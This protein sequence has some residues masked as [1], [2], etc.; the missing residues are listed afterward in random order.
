MHQRVR[1]NV[2]TVC[3]LSPPGCPN[4]L[5]SCV[6]CLFSFSFFS[7]WSFIYQQLLPSYYLSHLCYF[8][9]NSFPVQKKKT[10]FISFTSEIHQH[11]QILCPNSLPLS[12]FTP[13]WMLSLVTAFQLL[14]GCMER[15]D[16]SSQAHSD[17]RE[18]DGEGEKKQWR[19]EDERKRI[20]HTRMS[21]ARKEIWDKAANRKMGF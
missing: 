11:T 7:T 9:F 20:K 18:T 5:C 6:S 15:M 17:Q 21:K 14:Q 3:V 12:A 1:T 19:Q 2:T 8:F 4:T 13:V 16:C 10:R